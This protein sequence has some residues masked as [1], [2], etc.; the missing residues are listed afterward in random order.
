M[1]QRR[2]TIRLIDCGVSAFSS[3]ASQ[4]D[5]P[6]LDVGPLQPF[7]QRL[8]RRAD[9]KHPALLLGVARLGPAKLD[10]EA[11]QRGRFRIARIQPHRRPIPQLLDAQPRHFAAPAPA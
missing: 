2:L 8:D 10:C 1:A 3:T 7:A 4:R 6:L 9:Q 11:R 5:W